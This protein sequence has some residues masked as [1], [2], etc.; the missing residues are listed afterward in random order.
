MKRLVLSIGLL[1]L[2]IPAFAAKSCVILATNEPAT[3]SAAW[4]R[5]GY[6]QQFTLTYLAGDFPEGF[7]FKASIRDKEVDKIKKNG[8]RVIV[9]DPHYTR[10]DLEK[11]KQKCAQ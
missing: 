10:E 1:C 11:A 7:P 9:L 2:G 6:L 8:G 4:T 3:G 5:A